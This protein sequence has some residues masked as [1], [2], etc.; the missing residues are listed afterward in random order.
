MAKHMKTFDEFKAFALSR[1]YTVI[2]S[3]SDLGAGPGAVAEA[4]GEGFAGVY[5]QLR[6]KGQLYVGQ[7]EDVARRQ[8]QHERSGVRLMAFAAKP[9]ADRI[10]RDRT[11]SREIWQTGL[12]GY[13]T[14]NVQLSDQKRQGE[15]LTEDYLDRRLGYML[16]AACPDGRGARFG[17]A[18]AGEEGDGL[19]LLLSR[20]EFLEAIFV[21]SLYCSIAVMPPADEQYGR[22]WGAE[23]LSE[24]TVTGPWLQVRIRSCEVLRV[25]LVRGLTRSLEPR[26]FFSDIVDE[27]AE[28]DPPPAT[29]EEALDVL[30]EAGWR[31]KLL[32]GAAKR[33]Q[34]HLVATPPFSRLIPLACIR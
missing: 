1:G 10:E 26:Y 30:A 25:D 19:R 12:A 27:A 23:L 34:E 6:T 33:E 13:A 9:V 31:Q 18:L 4:L 28:D 2:L 21:V 32:F 17:A 22:R 14:D 11:E 15:P 7:A 8:K 5:L 20:P 3:P 16:A 29:L 24:G